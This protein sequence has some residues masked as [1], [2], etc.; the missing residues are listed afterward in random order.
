MDRTKLIERFYHIAIWIC[1]G[2]ALLLIFLLATSYRATA[3]WSTDPA[4][5]MVLCNAPGAQNDLKAIPDG[6]H[7]WFA[8]WTDERAV[9]GYGEL[10]GQ[11]LDSAG[12]ALWAANGLLIQSEP[13]SNIADVSPLLMPDGTLLVAYIYQPNGG[14]GGVIKVL[15][16]D[17]DGNDLWAAPVE[18]ARAGPG[19]LGNI[20]GFAGLKT[21]L[22]GDSA[23]VVWSYTPQGGNN[24]FA[25]EHIAL[26]GGVQFGSP[27]NVVPNTGY[28]SQ[29]SIHGDLAG[30]IIFVLKVG[31]GSPLMAIRMDAAGNAVWPTDLQV[32]LNTTGLQYTYA[33]DIAQNTMMDDNG[34]LTSVFMSAGDLPMARFDTAGTFVWAPTPYFACNESHGQNEPRLVLHDGYFYVGWADNR[35]PASNEDMY[36]QKFDMNGTPLWAADGVPVIQT[37]TYIPTPD[38][39][40]SDSGGV[41]ASFDGNTLGFAAMRLRSDGTLAWPAPVP[42]CTS[43]FNPF[44]E[45][46]VVQPDGN[47]GVVAFWQSFAGDLYGARVYRNGLL[48]N[49]VGVDEHSDL[50]TIMAYPNPAQDRVSFNLGN[51]RVV[52]A[53][54]FDGIGRAQ[55][56]DPDGTSLDVRTLAQGLHHVRLVCASGRVFQSTFIKQ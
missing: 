30:G 2:T 34:E 55:H 35:P 41:I 17:A 6:D 52:W 48:Y 3:Q 11:H 54:V 26:D 24:L 47:G 53:E 25:Y 10:Y 29:L 33:S 22:S 31:I 44:Y 18:I 23:Y 36:V 21:M 37:N 32:S 8:F 9:S 13:D 46:R 49:D 19:P 51:E 39:V 1:L 45:A 4:N 14:W 20:T 27:G 50:N 40:V 56:M 5:P 28:S 43:A 38:L 15:H 12:G 7:G 42:F 16:L